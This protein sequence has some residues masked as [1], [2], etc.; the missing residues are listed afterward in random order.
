MVIF[1]SSEL[2]PSFHN[3]IKYRVKGE[4]ERQN[5]K[6][7]R[8][9]DS[10]REGGGRGVNS[11]PIWAQTAPKCFSDQLAKDMSSSELHLHTFSCLKEG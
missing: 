10:E 6:G 4:Q 11:D 9:C 3:T 2:N 1:S 7:M 5:L 8:M